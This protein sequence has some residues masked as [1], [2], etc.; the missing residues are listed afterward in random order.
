MIDAARIADFIEERVV[1]RIGPV[2]RDADLV[3]M[4]LESIDAVLISGEIED[5]FGAEIEPVLM[6][7][8]RTIAGVAAIAERQINKE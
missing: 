8:G 7:E 3:D 4:G 1:Q 5:E 2:A 6:F